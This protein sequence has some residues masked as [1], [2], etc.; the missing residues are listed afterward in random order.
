[1]IS[2]PL[3]QLVLAACGA[4]AMAGAAR[5]DDIKVLTTCIMKGSFAQIAAQFERETGHT[6]TMSWGPSS[7]N[8]PE[9]SQVRIKSGEPVD[10]L[11]M[12]DKGMDEL[13]RGGYFVPLQR[14]DVAISQI[15][16][17]V[18]KGQ[19][20]P[21]IGSVDAV[22]KTLLAAKS[23]G[24]SEGASGHYISTVMLDKLGIAKEVTP[25][26][27]VILGRKF[28][29]E[30]LAAGEVE[31]GLQQLSELRLEPGVTV[32]GPLPE[33]LQK[34]SLVTAAVSSKA[35][36]VEAATRFVAF[37]TTPYATEAIQN[38]GLALPHR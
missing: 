19:P 7:G 18:K 35:R 31:L 4:L 26:S 11:I 32:V 21:D 20:L 6:L 17:A 23:I 33:A 28:V 30:A 16:V 5:A 8:S 27:K 15:G 29:G 34:A 13:I 36:N 9:A 3:K 12:V 22:R 1:M 25:K 24:Y 2:H 14:R 38:S 37:L 10:V